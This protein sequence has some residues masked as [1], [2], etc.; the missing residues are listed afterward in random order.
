MIVVDFVC[1]E[2]EYGSQVR[3][4]HWVRLGRCQL[5]G[6]EGCLIGHGYYLRKPK[7]RIAGQDVG[8]VW[9]KRWFCKLCHRTISVL[10]DFLLSF[11]HY[12]VPVIQA[13]IEAHWGCG[14]TWG[15]L[16]A[17]CAEAGAPAR[18]TMQRWCGSFAE[19]A[20]RWLGAVQATLAQQ[21]SRS[22]WLD[23]HGEALQ[24]EHLAQ[25][26]LGASEHL[27]AWG[28]TRWAE[29]AGYGRND[30]VRFMWWWSSGRGLG[31]LV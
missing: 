15:A 28:K 24:A 23:P 16:E 14:K 22:A 29:A 27:L 4:L 7:G 13:V 21:D 1:T 26:L 3:Q 9:I 5:C 2:Q 18:R 12:V 20:S 6:G 19:Q 17:E 31:R 25:A 30:R 11:R 8:T 10:P